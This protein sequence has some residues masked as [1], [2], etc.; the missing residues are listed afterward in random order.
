MSFVVLSLYVSYESFFRKMGMSVILRN[1]LNIGTYDNYTSITKF[2]FF[3]L[4]PG[5]FHRYLK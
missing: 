5:L 3:K 4:M 1:K 2:C